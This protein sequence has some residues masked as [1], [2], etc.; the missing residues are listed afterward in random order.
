MKNKI[1][2]AKTE[3]IE[4][5]KKEFEDSFIAEKFSN[6]K[7]DEAKVQKEYDRLVKNQESEFKSFEEYFMKK[8]GEAL[9][10]RHIDAAEYVVGIDRLIA[11]F[12]YYKEHREQLNINKCHMSFSFGYD[13]YCVDYYYEGHYSGIKLDGFLKSFYENKKGALA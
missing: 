10:Y 6:T 11:N 1:K 3:L 13:N 2:N 12:I 8:N 9:Q 4:V 7:I 5:L